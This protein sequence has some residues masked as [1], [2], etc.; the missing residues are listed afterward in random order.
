MPIP[1]PADRLAQSLRKLGEHDR[2]QVQLL[3]LSINFDHGQVTREQ[4]DQTA[5]LIVTEGKCSEVKFII[6]N[7]ID[8]RADAD[9]TACRADIGRL[10]IRSPGPNVEVLTETGPQAEILRLDENR[11]LSTVIPDR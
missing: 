3:A 6:R 9:Q 5:R 10:R 2:L 7:D 4:A 8:V 11:T 1:A